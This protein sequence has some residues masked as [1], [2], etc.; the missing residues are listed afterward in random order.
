L[1]VWDIGSNLEQI[2]LLHCQWWHFH[3]GSEG[4]VMMIAH[5]GATG[6]EILTAH[7]NIAIGDID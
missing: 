3:Q 7:L 6:G 1:I 2:A 4:T 5:G